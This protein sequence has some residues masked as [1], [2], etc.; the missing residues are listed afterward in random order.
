M[1]LDVEAHAST[2][3]DA[4]NAFGFDLNRFIRLMS[5]R[6]SEDSPP[7]ETLSVH[8]LGIV[9]R[10]IAMQLSENK[11][12]LIGGCMDYPG[13]YPRFQELW[14]TLIDKFSEKKDSI[15]FTSE[16]CFEGNVDI[17]PDQLPNAI[18]YFNK[19]RTELFQYPLLRVRISQSGEEGMPIFELTGFF[20]ESTGYTGESWFGHISAYASGKGSR[21]EGVSNFKIYWALAY[22]EELRKYLNVITQPS[23][24]QQEKTVIETQQIDEPAKKSKRGP[25]KYSRDKKIEAL[26]NWES[27]DRDINPIT[28]EE[29]LDYEFGNTGGVPNVAASTFHGWRKLKKGKKKP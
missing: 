23:D 4:L 18:R 2:T 14:N 24:R 26:E 7:E 19:N 20:R 12:E 16:K 3:M 1:K 9:I 28:L 22:F 15:P 10:F 27:L 13:I 11:T 6:Q 25:R 17:S 5:H 29:W 21:I 8:S